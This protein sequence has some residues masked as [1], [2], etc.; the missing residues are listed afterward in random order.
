MELAS[1]LESRLVLP[2]AVEMELTTAGMLEQQKAV[3]SEQ[4]WAEKWAEK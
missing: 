3:Q 4:R 1:W 2:V